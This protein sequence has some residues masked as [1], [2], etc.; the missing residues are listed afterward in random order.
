MTVMSWLRL[1]IC[2]WLI[3]KAARGAAWLLLFAVLV[4]V[5]PVTLVMIG[6]YL[7]ASRRGW[8]AA[9]LRRAAAGAL[10]ITA[11]YAAGDVLAQHGGTAAA[12][13]PARDWA[14][15]WQPHA[16]AVARMFVEVS[17][18]ALPAGLFLAAGLWAW[19]NYALSAGIG[20]RMA[21]APVT[22]DNRQWKR[23]VTAAAGR[24]AAPGSV[25][26]LTRKATIPIGGTI[27]AIGR[28][29]RPVFAV[30][31]AACA[32]HMVIVG[33]TGSGKT[34]LMIRLWA[35]W[36]TAALDAHYAGKGDRPLLI[37]V[38]C[39][40][41]RDAR[42]KAGRTRRLMYGAGARHVAIWPDDARVSVW[43]LPAPDLAVLLYQMIETGTGNAAYYADILHAVTVLAI[44]APAG[45]PHSA[46][47]FLERLD[48]HWLAAA[49]GVHPGQAARVRAAWPAPARH[50]APLRHPAQP[51]RCRLRRTRHPHRRRC[52]VLHPGRHPRTLRRRSPGAG[53]HRTG[54]PHR[55]R[56]GRRAAGHRA[57]RRRLLRRLPPRPAVQPVRTRPIP[58]H[59]RPGLRADLARARR[60]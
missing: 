29:W 10:I 8:P 28:P 50:P 22:F 24:T 51:A 54:R 15:G 47:T 7:A 32:R 58:R 16:L 13:A 42:K 18:V 60:R 19:R 57:G 4:A 9:R 25:P 27:R 41:G 33:A 3:R 1:T 34:N 2:L 20:G 45:P 49:W 53:H 12:L 44:T 46:A 14:H 55:H 38:D 35:G 48:E 43:D 37:V 59:R 52:L 6:G 11:I 40:G 21:S 26:L 56:P 36:F 31:A 17:P 39:K 5:W 23:Q 30:P